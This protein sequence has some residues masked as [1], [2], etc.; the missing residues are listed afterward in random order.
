LCAN[1]GYDIH[2]IAF[3]DTAVAPKTYYT[4][5]SEAIGKPVAPLANGTFC[6]SITTVSL[7]RRYGI[8]Y[9]LEPPGAPGPPGSV[10]RA[11]IAGE[12]LYFIPGAAPATLG[13]R[14]E[15]HKATDIGQGTPVAVTH[16]DAATWTMTLDAHATSTL[17]LRLTDVPG[18]HATVDGR[19]VPIRPWDSVMQRLTVPAGRHVVVV[20]YW[21][22]TFELGLVLAAATALALAI[23]IAIAVGAR[24]RRVELPQR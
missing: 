18:W 14:S 15:S 5:W 1:I 10:F 19:P 8:P 9:V 3:Y 22:A 23:A 16:P 2:E 20:S 13:P 4:S 6:P 7:A 11:T 12:G 21:P 17:Y 24:R